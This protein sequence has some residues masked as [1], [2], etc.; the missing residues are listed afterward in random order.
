LL[1]IRRPRAGLA[2]GL[3]GCVLKGEEAR[4][5]DAK[6]ATAYGL[7]GSA[8][9]YL[10]GREQARTSVQAGLRLNP[11]DPN[12]ATRLLELAI[13]D[14]LTANYEQAATMCS[15]AIRQHPNHRP[16]YRFFVGISRTVRRT[17]GVQSAHGNRTGWLRSLRTSRPPWFGSIDFEYMLEGLGKAGW[18]G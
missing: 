4:S 16:I 8:L 3:E 18:S 2:T 14:Y 15:E 5:L 9:L 7:R 10:H 17:G 11:L 12:R 6:C 1:I 13:S